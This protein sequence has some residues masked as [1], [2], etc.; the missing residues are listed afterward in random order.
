MP[1]NGTFPDDVPVADALEQERP[2]ADSPPEDDPDTGV[3]WR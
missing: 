1:D 2:T 3:R